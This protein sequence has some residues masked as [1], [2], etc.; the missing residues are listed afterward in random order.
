LH[1]VW[2]L[3]IASLRLPS[4]SLSGPDNLHAGRDHYRP[5]KEHAL[6]MKVSVTVTKTLY[7]TDSHT[8]LT[9]DTRMSS[10][11]AS[12]PITRAQ[13]SIGLFVIGFAMI[14]IQDL[15]RLESINLGF[16]LPF[17]VMFYLG[18]ICMAA[19]YYLR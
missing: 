6:M 1:Q 2:Q 5:G 18:L 16:P 12:F 15:K 10:N 14:A 13:F 19:G 3:L 17:A 7:Q 4:H 9:S 11:K 8:L